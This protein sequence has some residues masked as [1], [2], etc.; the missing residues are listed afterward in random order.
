MTFP[1]NYRQSRQ[2]RV[3]A[4]DRKLRDKEARREERRQRKSDGV[5]DQPP[6]DERKTPADNE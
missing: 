6:A 1:P 2:E 3:R 4:K 5:V